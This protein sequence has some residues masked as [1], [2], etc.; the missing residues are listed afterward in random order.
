MAAGIYARISSDPD[1]TRLGVRRQ[2]DD[3]EALAERLG[4]TVTDQYIDND[5]SAWSGK[6]RAPTTNGCSTTS[7]TV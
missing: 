2:I 4:W 3:C 1:G 7:R 6:K 5:V